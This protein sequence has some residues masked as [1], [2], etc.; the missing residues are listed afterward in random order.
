MKI[1]EKSFVSLPS[2]LQTFFKDIYMQSYRE[3]VLEKARFRLLEKSQYST[4]FLISKKLLYIQMQTI[5]RGKKSAFSSFKEFWIYCPQTCIQDNLFSRN[6]QNCE[7]PG[8]I[9]LFFFLEQTHGIVQFQNSLIQLLHRDF[10]QKY[11]S[12]SHVM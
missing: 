4:T 8:N 6:I 3:S 12:H 9:I 2:H 1:E 5:F 11:S 7:Y 10:F